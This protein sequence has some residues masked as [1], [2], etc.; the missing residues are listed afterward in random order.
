MKVAR[1]AVAASTAG[2][3]FFAAALFLPAWTVCFWQA[4]VFIGVFGVATL[5]STGYLAA[6][7][8]AALQRRLRAGP[9]AETC[10]LQR[11]AISATIFAVVAL[12]VVSALDHRS[13]WSSLPLPVVLFGNV[14]VAVGLGIAQLVV[15]QNG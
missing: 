9:A 3:A 2:A 12:L 11:V 5:L 13:D 4:W 14:M 6:R 8:P 10:P 7:Y 15:I 1:H